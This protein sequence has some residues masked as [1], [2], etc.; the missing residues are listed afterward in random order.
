[1][2]SPVTQMAEPERKL[3]VANAD[4]KL[5]EI[6]RSKTKLPCIVIKFPDTP[7]EAELLAR[8]IAANNKKLGIAP[9]A[10]GCSASR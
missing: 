8:A 2:T 5:V 1:M 9:S 3:W 7:E 10:S 6:D 4:G